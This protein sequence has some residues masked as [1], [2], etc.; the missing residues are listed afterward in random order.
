VD[1]FLESGQIDLVPLICRNDLELRVIAVWGASGDPRKTS[2]VRKAYDD[3]KRK[4][5]ERDDVNTQQR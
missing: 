2:V 1:L 3:L 4:G 5:P